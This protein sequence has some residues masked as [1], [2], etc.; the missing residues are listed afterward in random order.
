MK[1][2][3]YFF[4][5]GRK[6]RIFTLSDPIIIKDDDF[7][8]LNKYNLENWF[9]ENKLDLRDYIEEAK[10]ERGVLFGLCKSSKKASNFL[11]LGKFIS[12]NIDGENISIYFL[13]ERKSI[14][15]KINKEFDKW[16]RIKNDLLKIIKEIG[17]KLIY[18]G[19][20]YWK[21]TGSGINEFILKK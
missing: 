18:K 15:F 17:F 3:I 12:P 5:L 9:K 2:L 1:Q 4:G 13:D 6:E 7:S 20:G 11:K 19:A 14:L 21:N 10:Y 8:D 16:R